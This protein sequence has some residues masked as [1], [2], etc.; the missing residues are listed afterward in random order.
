ME[1]KME[2]LQN[3]RKAA[4]SGNS[5]SV[6]IFRCSD[7]FKIW[8]FKG[9]IYDNLQASDRNINDDIKQITDF[10]F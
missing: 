6:G 9:Q 10:T 3:I 2:N 8:R 1:K 4:F 7:K 5:A